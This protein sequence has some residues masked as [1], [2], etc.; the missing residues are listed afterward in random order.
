MAVI[1]LWPLVRKFWG[2]FKYSLTY[3][4]WPKG[5]HTVLPSYF[6]YRKWR[7]NIKPRWPRGN[8][9]VADRFWGAQSIEWRQ[10]WRDAVKKPKLTGYSLWM[11]EALFHLNQ[12]WYAPEEPSESGG[13]ANPPLV[14]GKRLKPCIA[15]GAE[16]CEWCEERA[17]KTPLIIY[18]WYRLVYE[19]PWDYYEEYVAAEQVDWSACHYKWPESTF[20]HPISFA[21]TWEFDIGWKVEIDDPKTEDMGA[22]FS[23]AF[24]EEVGCDYIGEIPLKKLG[25]GILDAKF[26]VVGFKWSCKVPPFPP[27]PSPWPPPEEPEEPEPPP[28]EACPGC[29]IHGE[30]TPLYYHVEWSVWQGGARYRCSYIMLIQV[31]DNPCM[32]EEYHLVGGREFLTRIGVNVYGTLMTARIIADPDGAFPP[33]GCLYQRGYSP[34]EDFCTW[35]GEIPLVRCFYGFTSDYFRIEDFGFEWPV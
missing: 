33:P 32:W 31:E 29:E 17:E 21:F 28:W 13:W 11:K 34:G 23:L 6:Q 9:F 18:A 15:C 19:E 4:D 7:Y 12:N 2:H 14:I 1:N 5:R 10:K 3:L 20:S 24:S 30:D 26:E 35:T 8:F 25:P 16:P 22:V 27:G